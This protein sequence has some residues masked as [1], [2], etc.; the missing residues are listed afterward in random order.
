VALDATK[1]GYVL[2]AN[3]TTQNPLIGVLAPDQGSLL[4]VDSKESSVQV[5]VSGKA[6]ALVSTLQGDIKNGDFIAQSPISG[7]G[8][9]AKPGQKVVGVA[10]T[11]F[12]QNS[13]GAK[14]EEVADTEGKKTT[15][16]IGS[17]SIIVAVGSLPGGQ[18]GEDSLTGVKQWLSDI[19]GKQVSTARV[20]TCGFIA[21]VTLVSIVVMVYSTIRNGIIATAR[22]PLAKP[23]IFEALAQTMAMVALVSVISLTAMYA[24]LRV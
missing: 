4:A 12:S 17:V 21:V 18:S 13:Q 2:L 1:E 20:I 16:Y 5:S 11:D 10:Q 22:N 19:A 15:V 24:I 3:S 9:K 14:T 7:V 8:M 6:N 23:A